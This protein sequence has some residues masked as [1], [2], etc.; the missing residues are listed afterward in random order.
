M[1]ELIGVDD[2]SGL[3]WGAGE[4][5]DGASTTAINNISRLEPNTSLKSKFEMQN[6]I[7]HPDTGM[8]PTFLIQC[9][10]SF[11]QGQYG[12]LFVSNSLRLNLC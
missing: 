6:S 8:A 7:R 4:E 5:I 2:L 9:C 3:C 12:I 1:Q 10:L 11:A